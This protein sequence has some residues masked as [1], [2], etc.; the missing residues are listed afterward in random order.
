MVLTEIRNHEAWLGSLER[1]TEEFDFLLISNLAHV[2]TLEMVKAVVLGQEIANKQ[3]FE[4]QP[5]N[6]EWEDTSDIGEYPNLIA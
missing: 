1:F 5:N 4:K 2:K 6:H 3:G